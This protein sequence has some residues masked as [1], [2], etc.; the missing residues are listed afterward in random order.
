[1]ETVTNPA[2][3]GHQDPDTVDTLE[4][5]ETT[6][7]LPDTRYA[8]VRL[9]RWSLLPRWGV[10]MR[11]LVALGLAAMYFYSLTVEGTSLDVDPEIPTPMPLATCGSFLVVIHFLVNAA[12]LPSLRAAVIDGGPLDQLGHNVLLSAVDQKRLSRSWLK[13]APISMF[14]VLSGLNN[15]SNLFRVGQVDQANGLVVTEWYACLILLVGLHSILTYT[16]TTAPFFHA[17]KIASIVTAHKVDR[18]IDAVRRVEPASTE[19]ETEVC[20]PALLL[21]TETLPQLST[22][23]GPSVG[24]FTVSWWIYALGTV[25]FFLD[26]GQPAL[27][28]FGLL[29]V[30]CPFLAARDVSA[31]SSRCDDLRQELNCKRVTDLGSHTIVDALEQA[32]DRLNQRQGLGFVVYTVVI[33]KKMQTRILLSVGTML[34]TALPLIFA[35]KPSA[36]QDIS[37]ATANNMSMCSLSIAQKNS[38]RT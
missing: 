30:L 8:S 16:L 7:P 3:P 27:I 31:T 35:L 18:V 34:S 32:L 37:S 26:N 14:W 25:C 28:V 10:A 11:W 20:A 22:G 9:L 15:I 17:L 13:V 19:W 4:T 33:D 29:G 5:G 6:C 36:A 24:L 1:M 23:F 12:M 2:G 38:I 21:A